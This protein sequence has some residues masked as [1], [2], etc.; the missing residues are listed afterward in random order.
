MKMVLDIMNIMDAL[1]M[2]MLT[3]D[4]WLQ[5]EPPPL[6]C[7]RDLENYLEKYLDNLS[8]WIKS[9]IVRLPVLYTFAL[10]TMLSKVVNFAVEIPDSYLTVTIA[11]VGST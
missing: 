5:Q 9:K 4:Q 1:I 3:M 2:V 8:I 7:G 10:K 6:T 11:P